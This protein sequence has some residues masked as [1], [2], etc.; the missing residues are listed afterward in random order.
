MKE[1]VVFDLG[2]VVFNW[3]P[4]V[5]LRQALPARAVDESSAQHWV[6]EIFQTF[7]PDGNWAQFDL[8]N[9]ESEV[10]AQRIARRTGLEEGEV[11]AVIDGLAPHMHVKDDTVALIH[12]LKTAGHRLVYLSNMPHGLSHW[13][14]DD[15]P[16]ADWFEDGIFSARVALMKPDPAIFRLTVERLGVRDPAPVFID[17]AQR[18]ID[19]ACALGWRGI[20]FET[21][22]QVGDQLVRLGL[23]PRRS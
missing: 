8:G 3:Q 19:A 22:R 20:R 6:R 16:F 13:I 11:M 1:T 10:L 21:A 23:L 7:D 4:T 9:A 14:E 5:L 2:G 12:D 18:N 15:H 17:D